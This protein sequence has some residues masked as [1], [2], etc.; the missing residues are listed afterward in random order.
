MKINFKPLLLSLFLAGSFVSID[1][2]DAGR[3]KMTAEEVKVKMDDAERRMNDQG[4]SPEEV[5]KAKNQYRRYK[6]M[7]KERSGGELEATQS[8]MPEQAAVSDPAVMA[9]QS[10]MVDQ[11]A[12]PAEMANETAAEAAESGSHKMTAAE[13]KVKMD[14]AERRMND[15]SLSPEEVKNAKNQYKKYK[16]KYK[17]RLAEESAASQAEQSKD[18]S[19]VT[20]PLVGQAAQKN[21]SE[22][23]RK[24]QKSTAE[25]KQSTD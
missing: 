20:V 25:Q 16:K 14:D 23:N 6:K 4:L 2:A 3:P 19:K 13:V 17:K 12:A 8:A 10:A 15:Q 5:K 9:D 1:M 22:S 18:N 11:T 24:K 21:S 7:Y